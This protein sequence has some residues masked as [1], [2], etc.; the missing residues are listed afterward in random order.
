MARTPDKIRVDINEAQRVTRQDILDLLNAY[1][2][3]E[4]EGANMIAFL[5]SIDAD[6]LTDG[7]KTNILN[8]LQSYNVG[9]KRD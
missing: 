2:D 6:V 4:N 8:D 9:Y 5:A 7:Q 1:G 3:Y